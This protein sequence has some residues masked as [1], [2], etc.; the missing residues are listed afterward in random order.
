MSEKGLRMG[1][2]RVGNKGEWTQGT[3]LTMARFRALYELPFKYVNVLSSPDL[4][5]S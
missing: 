1:E 3:I 5:S 2:G 4:F